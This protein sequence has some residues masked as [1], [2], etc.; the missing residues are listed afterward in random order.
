MSPADPTVPSFDDAPDGVSDLASGVSD[1]ASGAG[2]AQ[3]PPA[4]GD[5]SRA[6]PGPWRGRFVVLAGIALLALNLR[7]AVAAVS[8]ILDEVRRDVPLTP[9]QVGLLGTIPV[10]AFA[11]FGALT[12]ALA[13]RS[14]LEPTTIGALLVAVLGELG[15]A[16][17]T[18][19]AGFLGWTVVAL[20]GMGVGNVLLPPL[21]KRYFPDRI[22]DVTALYAVLLAVSTAAPPLLAVPVTAEHGWRVSLASWAVLGVL[23]ALVWVVVVIRSR[24]ARTALGEL[25]RRAPDHTPVLASRHRGGGRV[26]RSPLAWGMAVAF[27]GNSLL[28]YVMFAWYPQALMDAGLEAGPAGGWLGVFSLVGL[29][30]ALLAPLVAAWVRNPYP[31]IVLFVGMFLTGLVGLWQAPLGPTGLW[32]VLLGLGTGTFPLLLALINLRTR[33]SAGAASLSGFTQGIGYTLAGL[34]PLAVGVLYARTGGWF[35]PAVILVVTCLV[36]LVAGAI[37]C[38]PVWLEDTWGARRR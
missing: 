13:R 6:R 2:P 38:R 3:P 33:T 10:V 25:L 5:R 29:G 4:A 30:P 34:G 16:W 1:P 35:A 32:S 19:S 27:G 20:A 37:A 15:R 9:E 11:V 28:S 17:S 26:W 14:G 18:T 8:P 22:G 36:M 23:A 31:L 7:I 12:P 21:V 24:H